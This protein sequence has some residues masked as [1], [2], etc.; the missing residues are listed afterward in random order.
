MAWFDTKPPQ[1][2]TLKMP[3]LTQVAATESSLK[4]PPAYYYIGINVNFENILLCLTC[5]GNSPIQTCIIHPELI[6]QLTNYSRL[7]INKNCSWHVLSSSSFTEE[8]VERIIPATDGFITR[9]L[10][11]RLNSMLQAI[12]FPAS[13]A[14]LYTGL[15]GM[16]RDTFTLKNKIDE[17]VWSYAITVSKMIFLFIKT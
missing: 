1:L 7:K 13:I 15:S 6:L 11:I 8:G 2:R 9:H 14:N 10:A 3:C 4:Q 16:H 5:T 17:H 12:Q